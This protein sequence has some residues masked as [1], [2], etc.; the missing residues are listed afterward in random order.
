MRYT[1]VIAIVL[2][3]IPTA[4]ALTPRLDES[5]DFFAGEWAGNA[6]RGGYCYLNLRAD[7]HGWV[8]IDGGSGDWLGARIDWH[9]HRQ[10]V[11]VAKIT[12]LPSTT[13]LRV[14]PLSGLTLTTEFN[15]SL[16]LRWG[17]PAS[18]CQLQKIEATAQHLMQARA[19]ATTLR[20]SADQK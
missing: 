6:A 4:R 3:F 20:S 13:Q 7:G 8:L 2:V 19:L 11:A 16:A 9:N 1:T 18:S 10:A 5:S 17:Q 15:Q 14:M 12:P